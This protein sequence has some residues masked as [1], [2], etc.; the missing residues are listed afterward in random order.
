MPG[1]LEALGLRPIRR[2]APA[3][4]PPIIRLAADLRGARQSLVT[5]RD[6]MAQ[7]LGRS[8]AQI[9]KLQA[10]L[11]VHPDADLRSIAGSPEFGINAL[12]GNYRVKVIAAIAD[13]EAAVPEKL[14]ALLNK[15]R[16]LVAGFQDHVRKSGRLEACDENPLGVAVNVR[17]QLLPALSQLARSIEQFAG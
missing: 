10:L 4:P 12:T 11:A 16:T 1:L 9:R 3:A 15:A 7:A 6:A 5:A 8:D 17:Q 2:D 14:P 13:L